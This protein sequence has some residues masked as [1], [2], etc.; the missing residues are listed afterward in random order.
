MTNLENTT[1]YNSKQINRS[2]F[3]ETVRLRQF[4]SSVMVQ[5]IATI[6]CVCWIA[7]SA[8]AQSAQQP[9]RGFAPAGTYTLSEIESI[10]SSNGNVMFSIP[11]TSLPVNQGGSP[12]MGLSLLYNSK[13]FDPTA[14]LVPNGS[15]FTTRTFLTTSPN[16]NWRY[17]L[18]YTFEIIDRRSDYY[19][20]YGGT[21]QEE[22]AVRTSAADVMKV[23][24]RFPDGS[25]REFRPT[26]IANDDYNHPSFFATDPE[27]R[28][29]YCRCIPPTC[30]TGADYIID[31]T[32]PTYQTR[33]YYSSDGT[34]E[35][36]VITFGPPDSYGIR[37]RYWTLYFSNGARVSNDPSLAVNGGQRV[38]DRN[39]NYTDI[40]STTSN[41]NPATR[42]VDQLG[43]D[44][45]VEYGPSSQDFVYAKGTAGEQ[46]RWTINW[47]TTYVN[48][49]YYAGDTSYT[50]NFNI[51]LRVISR[52][53]LPTQA[54]G[55]S[56]SFEYNG[57]G[58]SDY[59]NG[60]TLNPSV[61]WGEVSK[62]ILTSGAEA[63][64]SYKRDNEATADSWDVL[65]NHPLR[66]DLQYLREYDGNAT[67][68]TESTTYNYEFY[69]RNRSAYFSSVVGP[70]GGVSTNSFSMIDG[71][72]YG[73]SLVSTRPDGSTIERIWLPNNLPAQSGA[74]GDINGYLKTEFIS[75]TG[76]MTAIKDY[77]YDKN[78]NVR[79]I[80]EYDWVAQSTIHSGPNGS[81]TIPASAPLKR[82]MV[83]S[84]Y[85]PTPDSSDSTTDDPDSY[86]NS[87]SAR[88][89]NA[90]FSTEIQNGSEQTVSRTE[91]TYDN[92]LTTGNLTEQRGW[93]S[94]KGALPQG[95]PPLL[96]SANS[97]S[98]ATE[99]TQYGM[100]RLITDAKGN[101]T[102]LTYGM[103]G[104]VSDLYATQIETAWGT[105]V[106][107]TQTRQYDLNTGSVTGVFDQ[108]NNVSTLT[109]YDALGRPI[110]VRRA[111]GL[112]DE[113]Q[114]STQYSDAER[115]ITVRYDLNL[116]GDGKLATIQ[117]FDQLGR[118]RLTRQLEEFSV[119][120]LTDETA[121]IKVQ[122]RYAISNPC[123]PLNDQACLAA[124]SSTLGTYLTVSNPYRATT[125]AGASSEPTMG[126]TRTLND[127][128]GHA[129]E[130]QTFSGAVLPG[131]WAG[132][133]SSTGTVST[134]YNGMFTT[135]TDQTGRVRRT[136]V[137]ALGRL[138]RVD[139]PSDASNTL[140]SQDNPNQPT[141]YEYDA[142]GN[143]T[144][145]TQG[146]QTR[147]FNYTSLARLAEAIN[148]ESGSSSYEYDDNGNL[149]TKTDPRLL[150]NTST[151]IASVYIYDS[152]NRITSRTYND[153]TPNVSYV[154]DTA[155]IPHSKG[156]L[157]SVS[158]SVS[159]YN[160]DEYDALGRV[161]SASQT[162]D[163][164][165]YSM[166]YMYNCAGALT[167][168][169][170]PSG[171][172]V[173][174]EYN[175]GGKLA[176]VKNEA[177]TL[178]YAGAVPTDTANRI[179]YAAH[180]AISA[181][182]LGNALWEHTNFN[183]RLQSMQIGLGT[184][185]NNSSVLQLDYSYGTTN[186]NGNLQTQTIT[187]PGGLTL[188]QT[189]TYDYLNRLLTAQETV[190]GNSSW[191]QIFTYADSNGQNTRYGNRR[192]DSGTTPGLITENPQFDPSTNRI[193]PQAGEQYQYDAAGNLSRNK[194]GHTFDYD[195]EN[196][197]TH[198]D[199]G[200]PLSGGTSYFYDGNG[201]RV[202]QTT[203]AGTTIFVYNVMGQ[204]VAEY[205][206]APPNSNG[207]TYV[208]ADYL[209]TPRVMTKSDGTV[210][211]RH[212]YLPFGEE[213]SA[214][215]GMRSTLTG[216]ASTDTLRQKFTAKERDVETGLDY[217]GA[218]YY[219]STQGR[220]TSPD[221]FGG[222]GFVSVPQSWN[223]YTYCLN[224]PF[225]FT[226][227]SGMVWL[228][229]N[230]TFFFWVD[231][232][233]YRKHRK[234]YEGYNQANGAV[235]QVQSCTD[236]SRCNGVNKGDWVQF[237]ANG[238]ISV[239]ADPTM[240][241]R[242]QYDD[243]LADPQIYAQL[244]MSTTGG[245][246]D[247]NPLK[248]PPGGSTTIYYENGGSQTR[249]YDE[250]GLPWVD[251]DRGHDHTGVGDPH[252]HWWDWNKHP[253]DARLP[254]ESIP[255]GWDMWDNG[256]P[257][258][259]P[260]GSSPTIPVYPV[261]F[262]PVPVRPMVPIRPIFLEPVLVP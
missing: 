235:G 10:N 31:S 77:T 61:G 74:S 30:N 69:Q 220:F 231:D 197:Q 68:V 12:G 208:T 254:P 147:R 5:I 126:W 149:K 219:S 180:G 113:T 129:V 247:G 233:E 116:A 188:T 260:R 132:N 27:G 71:F 72:M 92:S 167:S 125:S 153:G 243:Q 48:K 145:V 11:I 257:I 218:R 84:Y 24:M 123:Q 34:Y 199:G 232:A 15:T 200:N 8:Q 198:Y 194:T 106:K 65:Q 262:G 211:G 216:Y 135:V 151:H 174:S 237:N 202:K 222:S 215:Y 17:V 184:A 244:G 236:T 163:G 33:T 91:Y 169:R 90:V 238:T 187:L 183:P 81:L 160:Y 45:V 156:R 139:E 14:V 136:K 210:I 79:K 44:I 2:A 185:N 59:P 51:G 191:Q 157:T 13:V 241:I 178:Y 3:I 49:T 6:S 217:F 63:S 105:P 128:A 109:S 1:R 131:P 181:M 53:T 226:D 246:G 93:D 7:I 127:K 261:P 99:Y 150:P 101:R 55:L 40:L 190:G 177:T 29:F 112:A 186:N 176:G 32:A 42:I 229:N 36:L 39:N 67:P 223:K 161:K 206:D 56:Y 155:S 76:G 58:T 96:T 221:P 16:G 118:I 242:A 224:R 46:L 104:V 130:L 37:P 103:I 115:R 85:S 213:I 54:G 182:R 108:D 189:Y 28:Q 117:H 4:S 89:R 166:N 152:L 18:G 62:M 43:R 64:Y 47:T 148:P 95:Q 212:D 52:I 138:V 203:P 87:G 82:M 114:T 83:N 214:S 204:L 193:Q 227:P 251:V 119:V 195:A 73:R 209:G 171:R 179:Q 201:S 20:P 50:Q 165:V 38:F 21:P 100:P 170:Y 239:V 75:I 134:V 23:R 22:C 253:S 146:V 19:Y 240:T 228:T 249:Y 121:G 122:T 98:V 248:G 168:Q 57:A 141:F 78:G 252:V 102:Q 158:S 234:N 111:A 172:V 35:K 80:K 25:T 258:P 88:L 175:E 107:R 255:W 259:R 66:R 94:T 192:I 154:Y 60:G 140:G 173:K 250:K 164:Q 97:I 159:T 144:V 205:S 143:L 196:K 142:L 133:T 41:G 86:Y 9:Q 120:A 230:N 256:E 245:R 124:N 137:D 225:I 162:T 70:D 110:L 207:T 26:G